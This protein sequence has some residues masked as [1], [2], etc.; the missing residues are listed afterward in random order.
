MKT[1]SRQYPHVLATVLGLA[2]LT[3]GPARATPQAGGQASQPAA[4]QPA[5][6]QRPA[7]QP[8]AGPPTAGQPPAGQPAGGQPP[9]AQP[10]GPTGF[11]EG[12]L[13]F[14]EQ[15]IAR[16]FG[17]GY[18]VVSADV[19][20][21]KQ[22]DILA[23]SG[24]ELVWFKAPGWEKNV[25]LPAGS[26][27]A[28]NVTLAP[29]DID[30]DGRLDVALGAGW[31]RQNTGTLQWVRQNAPGATPAW[32]VFPISAEPTLH[33]IKWADIDGDSKLELI[34]APLHGKGAKGAEGPGARLLVFR[35]PARPQS[36]P[37][38]I[39]VAGESNHIQHNFLSMDLDKDPQQELVTASHEGLTAWKRGK[40]GAWSHTVIGQGSPG[41]VKLG[42]IG[43]HRV[44]ATVE[45]WHGAG[46]AVY[47]EK[48]G[49]PM[50][51]K[52]TI[53]NALTEGHAL[54][55]ADFDGDGNEELT[56][57]WRRGKPGVAIY[58]VDAGGALKSK[59]MVDDGGMDTE[60]LIVGDFN[61]DKRPDIVASGRATRNIKIYW[62][63]TPAKGK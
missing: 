47:V 60:D 26:T 48:P 29:H 21:D 53:E 32:E 8:P 54:G 56:V 5:A 25:I 50:W 13:K 35:P 7:G 16:D 45:P 2:T 6:G 61:G 52:T 38:Q 39:E 20:G 46:V 4:G 23:I 37:W 14:R 59:M 49:A 62:N 22:L 15:E 51:T 12:P 36:E 3:A 40:D 43:G 28:D 42:R 11:T 57:G 9:G 19:D 18:A 17:V 58:F 41:E 33:R 10:A 34:V 44:L 1:F 30:G 31:T 24:T 63:E 55:W 27:T